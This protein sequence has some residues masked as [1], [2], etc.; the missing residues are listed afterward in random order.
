M[1]QISENLF[2]SGLR[3]ATMIIVLFVIWTGYANSEI[4]SNL[5]IINMLIEQGLAQA[6]QKSG[7]DSI[8]QL[9]VLVPEPRTGNEWLIEQKLAGF[10]G[11]NQKLRFLTPDRYMPE[12]VASG[13]ILEFKVIDINVSYQPDSKG[14]FARHIQ[15]AWF[16]KLQTAS[17]V[18]L[19]LDNITKS[20]QDQIAR[21]AVAVIENRN[22]A[23]TQGHL[24]DSGTYT[25]YIEP[26]VV[27][28]VSGLIIYLF[29][30]MRSN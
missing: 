10:L 20:Y 13:W 8:D 18:V 26:I 23:I 28:I 9:N 21:N 30:I 22:L 17:G 5:H 15:V 6:F 27:S 19:F 24:P 16:I 12:S 7:I 2:L 25:K 14:I 3:P 29:F 11:S 4:L 1:L